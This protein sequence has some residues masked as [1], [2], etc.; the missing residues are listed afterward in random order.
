MTRTRTVRLYLDALEGRAVPACQLRVQ[1]D[2]LFVL[3]D[4]AADVVDLVRNAGEVR[5]TC[6]QDAPRTFTGILRVVADLGD[7]ND[8]L[9]ASLYPPVVPTDQPVPEFVVF[10]NLGGGH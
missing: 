2:T 10:A 8:Q 1:G 7:G 3:G 9:T 4:R 6:G 5:V